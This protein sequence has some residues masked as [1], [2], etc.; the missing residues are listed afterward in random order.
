MAGDLRPDAG[1]ARRPARIGYLAQELPTHATRLPLLAAFAAGRPGPPDEYAEQLLS[2]GLFREQDLHVP[3]AALSVGQRRRLQF[4]TLVTRPADP[5]RPRRA[6]QPHRTRP[7]RGPSGG[8]RGLPGGGGRG[9]AR[10]RLPRALRSRAPGPARRP[11]T[12][13]SR[14]A[15]RTSGTSHGGGPTRESL[16]SRPARSCRASPYNATGSR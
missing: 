15:S 10:S 7:D 9:L 11:Q 8:A 16:S 4:A 6:D 5:P 13:T 1:T 14:A 12:L 2:L 3:V